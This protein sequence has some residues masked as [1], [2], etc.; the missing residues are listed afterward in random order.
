M[1]MEDTA[2]KKYSDP[3]V[4]ICLKTSGYFLMKYLSESNARR[5]PDLNSRRGFLV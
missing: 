3:S 5:P 4:N 1:F 2:K